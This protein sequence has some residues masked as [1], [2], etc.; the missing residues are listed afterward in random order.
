MKIDQHDAFYVHVRRELHTGDVCLR[1]ITGQISKKS[2]LR[3]SAEGAEARDFLIPCGAF[4]AAGAEGASG[5]RIQHAFCRLILI[6]AGE[7]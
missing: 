1:K 2:I 4:G 7:K 5:A 3:R 6:V